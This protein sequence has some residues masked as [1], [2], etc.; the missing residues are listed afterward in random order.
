MSNLSKQI[1]STL[2][3][4]F[5]A[6]APL[7]EPTFQGREAEYVQDCLQKGEVSSKGKYVERFAKMLCD[8]TGAKYAIPVVNGTAAL[9]LSLLLAGIKRDDEVLVPSLTFVATANAVTYC[10]AIPHFVDVDMKTLGL[11]PAKLANYLAKYAG[12]ERGE[13]F[14]RITRRRIRAIL[15]M[16]TFGHPVDMEPLLEIAKHYH[17]MVIEDAAQALG[18]YY[19]SQHVGTFGN[20]AV[21][22]FNG[23]KI[24]TT[25][26]GGAI[27]TNDAD[28]AQSAQHFSTTAK[29][30]MPYE[31]IHDQVGYNYR[32][33]NLNAALGCAQMEQ[34]QQLLLQKRRLSKKYQMA[35]FGLTGV[36][37]VT[38]QTWADSNH[39]LNTLILDEKFSQELA[40]ILAVTNQAGYEIRPAWTPL[41]QLPIYKNCPKMDLSVTENLAKRSINLPSSAHLCKIPSF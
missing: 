23:N 15:P 19:Y 38:E 39:W 41:H 33:P 31:F 10:R 13:C 6:P 27:L 1:L 35:L 2:Q 8:F 18:S 4:L 17:L 14:N 29:M 26:G 21:L 24:I 22:S 25:G 12:I 37:F 34:L 9:H 32:M 28:L 7:H 36:R 16:H 30:P 40:D 5:P 11:D 3:S 20:C